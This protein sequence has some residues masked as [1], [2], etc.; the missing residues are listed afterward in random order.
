MI[1]KETVR[2]VAKLAR[3]ELT[4][5]EEEAFT[6]QL[7]QILGYVDQLKAVDTKGVEPN[8]QALPLSNVLRSDEPRPSWPRDEVLANA[9]AAEQGMF[10]VPKIMGD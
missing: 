8:L 4:P 9:P 2:H 6:Q 7:G 1:T 3:L 10:R 5:D